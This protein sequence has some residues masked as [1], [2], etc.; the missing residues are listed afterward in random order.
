M[1]LRLFGSGGALA[2]LG[3]LAGAPGCKRTPTEEPEQLL[4]EPA[5]GPNPEAG[6]EPETPTEEAGS[7]DDDEGGREDDDEDGQDE[8]EDED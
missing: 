7:E 3:L 2:C 4:L 1:F 5:A 8:G 6:T